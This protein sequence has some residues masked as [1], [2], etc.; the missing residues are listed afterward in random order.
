MGPDE[1]LSDSLF[2]CNASPSIFFPELDYTEW[3]KPSGG[4][5]SVEVQFSLFH[6]FLSRLDLSLGLTLLYSFLGPLFRK[7]KIMNRL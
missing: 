6:L 4:E 5:P 7:E 1:E 3:H 2:E